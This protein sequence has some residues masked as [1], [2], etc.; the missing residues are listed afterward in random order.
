M[1]HFQTPTGIPGFGDW[2]KIIQELDPF[3]DGHAA[4]RMGTYLHRLIQGFD[5][6]LDRE[7]VMADA[8]E[9]YIQEWGADKIIEIGEH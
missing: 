2:S 5:Q 1:D 8:A 9:M 3:R 7:T 4:R 6:G